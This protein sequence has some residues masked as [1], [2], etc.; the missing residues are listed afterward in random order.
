MYSKSKMVLSI[1]LSLTLIGLTTLLP[2]YAAIITLKWPNGP[3]SA[4]VDVNGDGKIDYVIDIC[5]WNLKSASGSITMTFDTSNRKLVTQ[6]SITNAN[7]RASVNG[8]PEIYVGRKP[9]D[10][11]YANGLGVNFPLKVSTLITKTLTVSYSYNI[12]S[13]QSSM[14]FNFAA[15]AWIVR[16]SVKNNPGQGP[17][18]GDLEI[19]VWTYS[20]NMNPAGSKVG[21]VTIGGK[22]WEVYRQG[23]IG[24]GWQYIAFKLK[25]QNIKSGTISYNAAAFVNAA[26]KYATFDI[27]NHYLLDWEIGTEWGTQSSSGSAS[28]KCTISG[29]SISLK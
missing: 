16:E 11:S 25:G 5:S 9:W 29:Y 22:T 17:G 24:N 13:V 7:P 28:F 20:Q 26:K 3:T 4:R 2:V 14:N 10:T 12:E 8:Y 15:D 6:C 21:E 19:M 27:S 18:A 1:L 23:S